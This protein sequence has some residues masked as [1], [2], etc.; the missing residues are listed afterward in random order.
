MTP[1]FDA[2]KDSMNVSRGNSKNSRDMD[3]LQRDRYELLSAYL[4][5]EVTAAERK[6]VQSWLDTDPQMQQLYVRMMRL[7]HGIQTIPVPQS[8]QPAEQMAKQVF[9]RINR[10][11]TR[12]NV[13]WGG[14]AIAAVFVGALSSILQSPAPQLAQKQTQP[15]Q[16]LMIALDRPAV[17]IPKAAVAEPSG[18]NGNNLD[19]R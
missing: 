13:V 15:N 3:V 16:P 17:P 11:I 19:V 6:Q 5:G 8:E 18:R 9:A 12:R 14:A 10:R 1:D 2:R 7:R 4:D